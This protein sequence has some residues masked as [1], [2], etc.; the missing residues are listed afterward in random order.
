MKYYIHGHRIGDQ[1]VPAKSLKEVTDT[2]D[3]TLIP[4]ERGKSTKIKTAIL[5]G[6]RTRGWSGEVSLSP[7]SGITI[8]SQKDNVGLCFQTGNMA[9]MYADLMKLQALYLR[10]TINVGIFIVPT[11]VTARILGDNLANFERLTN[12][13]EIFERVISM[14]LAIIGLE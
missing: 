5:E 9:R 12:E 13:M 2:I 10:D 14:P 1:I 7:H 3:A 4:V 6:L 11:T 8:T